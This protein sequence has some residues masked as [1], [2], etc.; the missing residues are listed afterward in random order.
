MRPYAGTGL[1][2]PG[3]L[4]PGPHGATLLGAAADP[5]AWFKE[6]FSSYA[7]TANLLAN[8][9]GWYSTGEDVCG[10]SAPN[11]TCPTSDVGTIWLD[12][13]VGLNVGGH[14]LTQSMRYDQVDGGICSGPS[15]GRNITLPSS[16]TEVW[17]SVWLKWSVGWTAADS[18]AGGGCDPDYKLLFGRITGAGDRWSLGIEGGE[19]SA[20]EYFIASYPPTGSSNLNVNFTGSPAAGTLAVAGFTPDSGDGWHRVRGHWKIG[21]GAND[22]VDAWWF[23][24]NLCVNRTGINPSATTI[25]GLALG[26]NMNSGPQHTPQS[27]WWGLVEAW[28]T[29]PGWGA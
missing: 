6:D 17:V 1:V 25:Y 28:N 11:G 13:G 9:N 12:T 24:N 16:V 10:N 14:S 4:S 20:D 15:V 3:A 27:Y 22:G 19:G 18:R 29:D 23:D 8:P 5:P 2:A 21:T 7:S 26:R